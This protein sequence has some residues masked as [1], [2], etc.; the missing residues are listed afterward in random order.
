MQK[1]RVRGEEEEISSQEK[2]RGRLRGMGR[3]MERVQ[4][5]QAVLVLST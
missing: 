2:D 3:G 4:I 1:D 5:H